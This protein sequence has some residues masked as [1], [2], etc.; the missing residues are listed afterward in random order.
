[1]ASTETLLTAGCTTLDSHS[2]CD[3][4]LPPISCTHTASQNNTTWIHL[5]PS[6]SAITERWATRCFM[7]VS[8]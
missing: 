5:K 8:S 3:S 2:S 6:S 1:V 7:S 4:L